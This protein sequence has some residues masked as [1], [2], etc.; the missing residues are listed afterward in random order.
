MKRAQLLLNWD[1]LVA[2]VYKISRNAPRLKKST[3]IFTV[4][5]AKNQI[6]VTV[7]NKIGR[8]WPCRSCLHKK[9]SQNKHER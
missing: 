1:Y 2:T 9:K 6:T 7:T 8:S 3:S 5:K 4:Q